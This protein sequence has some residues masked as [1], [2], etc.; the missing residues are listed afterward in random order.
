MKR[1]LTF[2]NR[3]EVSSYCGAYDLARRLIKTEANLPEKK[4][5]LIEE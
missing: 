5:I 2:C 3:E 1:M 4:T